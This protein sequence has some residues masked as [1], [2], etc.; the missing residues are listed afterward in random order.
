MKKTLLSAAML[1]AVA[2]APSA[3]AATGKI[4]FTGKVVAGTCTVTPSTGVTGTYDDMTVAM[5]PVQSSA[6]TAPGSYAMNT[7]FEIQ[8]GGQAGDT[9]TTAT[10]LHFEGTTGG[11]KVNA[12]GFLDNASTATNVGVRVL[13]A[14]T[15]NVVDLNSNAN[16][17]SVTPA[18]GVP[19]VLKYAA[20]YYS[21]NGG[22]TVGD[23]NTF[24]MY[25]IQY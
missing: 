2:A 13:N 14:A 25:T 19:G 11:G 21:K 22:A 1:I 23:V 17:P 8:V 18:A 6:L 24:V 12:D 16:N 4:T 20:Q 9:C 5:A 10:Q 7:P 15:G 3:F